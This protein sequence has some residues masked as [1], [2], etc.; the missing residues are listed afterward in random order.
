[1]IDLLYIVLGALLFAAGLYIGWR[2]AYAKQDV[3]SPQV[4]PAFQGESAILDEAPDWPLPPRDDPASDIGGPGERT[5][6]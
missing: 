2:A 5:W 1:M 4:L 3:P 6:G